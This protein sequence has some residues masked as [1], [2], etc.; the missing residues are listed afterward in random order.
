MNALHIAQKEDNPFACEWWSLRVEVL[1]HFL[2]LL[3]FLDGGGKRGHLSRDYAQRKRGTFQKRDTELVE[4]PMGP[5]LGAHF[6]W[7]PYSRV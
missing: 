1:I 7:T 4:S 3:C 5:F 6:S 2:P